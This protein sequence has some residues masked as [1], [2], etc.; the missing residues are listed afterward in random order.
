[1]GIP[2][3]SQE[4]PHPTSEKV[5]ADFLDDTFEDHRPRGYGQTT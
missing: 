4:R 5:P 3:R 1:M 2:H